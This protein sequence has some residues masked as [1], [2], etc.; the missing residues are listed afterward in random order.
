MY[1]C[2]IITLLNHHPKY[3]RELLSFLDP[4][5]G[6]PVTKGMHTYDDDCELTWANFTDNLDH[7]YLIHWVD[8]FMVSFMI[9]NFYILHF[10]HIFD[11]VLELSWQHI[12]PHFREC[13]WD[14]IFCDILLSNIPAITLSL[15]VQKRYGLI[16]YDFL[17]SEGKK[18]FWEWDFLHCHRKFGINI[19]IFFLFKLCFLNGF[20]LNNNLLIPPVHAFPPMR[21]FVWFGIGSIAFREGYE[22]FRTWNTVERKFNVVEGRYRWL[23]ISMIITE[24]MLCY[25]YREGTGHIQDDAV[26]PL[27]ISIPWTAT[28]VGT[29]GYW[30]YLRFKPGHTVKYPEDAPSSMKKVKNH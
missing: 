15:W 5:M 18:S 10:Q 25:K 22:D 8:W 30:L 16:S 13:W 6:V 1:F 3:G 27:Y 2:F 20:F 17:G 23:A 4:K 21:L 24:A 14:H 12:L 7:Y 11:E 19:Y 28:A 9:R 26:T 29:F